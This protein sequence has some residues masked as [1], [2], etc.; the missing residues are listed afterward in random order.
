MYK[1]G[2]IGAGLAVYSPLAFVLVALGAG[3]LAVGG[4]VLVGALAMLPDQDQRVPLIKHRGITHTVW[5]AFVVGGVFGV[6][7]FLYGASTGFLT[8]L[9]VGLFGFVLGVLVVG[10]HV[11]ADA[12][13][14]MGVKP[15]APVR[16]TEYSFDVAK[17]SNPIANVVLLGL[18]VAATT[19]GVV[20]GTAL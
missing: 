20:A 19:L 12:L 11:A 16:D 4:A 3:N 15:F 9:A 10:S 17:A 5:F 2:H 13:T 8:G 14:P 18:G 6:G 7:G 1:T